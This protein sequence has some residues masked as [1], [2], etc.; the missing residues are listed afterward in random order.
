MSSI[1][2]SKAERSELKELSA[3]LVDNFQII[4]N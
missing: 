2:L 3:L 4:G 1:K